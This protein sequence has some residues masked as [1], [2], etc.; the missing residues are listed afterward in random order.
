MA[1]GRKYRQDLG[2]EGGVGMP[3]RRDDFVPHFEPLRRFRRHTLAIRCG[4][5]VVSVGL[6]LLARI[7]LEGSLSG[8]QLPFITFFPA[9]LVSAF[10]GGL[11]PG[12]LSL[13]LSALAANYF[14]LPPYY[15]LAL[16]WAD[17][18]AV[19][20]SLVVRGVVVGLIHLL[21][22]AID[23]ITIQEENARLIL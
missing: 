15:S 10:L 23:R 18:I 17:A 6:G 22:E 20:L 2:L 4:V 16:S 21:N 5:A 9:L 3:V 11:G 1:Q 7:G 14:F 13:L 8:S 12:V 19:A